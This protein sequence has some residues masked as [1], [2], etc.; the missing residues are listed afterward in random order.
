M[1]LIQKTSGPRNAIV[2]SEHMAI[3]VR[4]HYREM[5]RTMSPGRARNAVW[6]ILLSGL[7]SKLTMVAPEG[8]HDL[9]R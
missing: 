3:F 6:A 7:S 4:H 9:P 8:T 2:V 1:I 5:R